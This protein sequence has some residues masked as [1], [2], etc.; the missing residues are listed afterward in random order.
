VRVGVVT[1]DS[2]ALAIGL[3]TGDV[4]TAIDG[5]PLKNLD[6]LLG[7]YARLD[8]LNAVELS[9]TRAGKPLVRNLR[10]R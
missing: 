2:I 9:G 1:A 6:Q 8:Q 3:R 7:L 5:E 10:L 4:L